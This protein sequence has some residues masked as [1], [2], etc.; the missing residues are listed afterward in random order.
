VEFKASVPS[1]ADDLV[2]EIAAFATSNDGTILLG[3][4]DAGAI[5]GTADARER[6]EG[7]ARNV[8]PHPTV[9]VDL[10]E[11]AGRESDPCLT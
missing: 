6:Y 7:I 9:L 5:V 4:T 2:K 1:N 10:V 3:V 8:S 11:L